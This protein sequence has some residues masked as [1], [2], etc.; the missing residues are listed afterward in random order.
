[1]SA[2]TAT[3][4]GRR[5]S[6]IALVRQQ[7]IYEQRTF[8]RNRLGALF[9]IGFS[10]LFLLLLGLTTNTS[11][12][13]VIGGQKAIQYYVPSFLAYGIMSACFTVLAITLV[14]RRE[15]GL[16]KRLRLSP[17]PAWAM[18]AALF[19][20]TVVVCVAQVVVLLVIGRLGFHL[21]GPTNYAALI[22]ALVVGVGCFSA[23]GVAVSTII[24]NQDAGG[25]IVNLV[26]FT[27]LFVSGTWYP[28][29]SG[30][31]LAQVSS[32]LPVRSLITAT[33][34]PFDL[35]P[36]VSP[37]SWRDI[38]VMLVWGALGAMLA[39][40]YFRWEPRRK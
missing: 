2:S 8:W 3:G 19:L 27:L 1:M 37:W 16:L 32:Y 5:P 26:F 24:P 40:R 18:M 38:A 35:R 28:L 4:V 39:V 25:P 33:F 21:H 36:G 11:R 14:N 34:A 12:L 17:L 31:A 10:T 13:K 15:V 20:S 30:S 7:L 9:T 6:D 22:V 23:L 29:Q